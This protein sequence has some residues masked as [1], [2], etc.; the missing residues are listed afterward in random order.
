MLRALAAAIVGL[1][2]LPPAATAQG[3][4]P[5]APPVQTTS[6]FAADTDS[7]RPAVAYSPRRDVFVLAREI[8]VGLDRT[9]FTTAVDRAGHALR[10]GES[11]VGKAP[12]D[13]SDFSRTPR[14]AYNS[15]ADE[16]LVTWIGYSAAAGVREDDLEVLARRLDGLGR[17]VGAV[18]RVSQMGSE[19]DP[20]SWFPVDAVDVTYH[21]SRDEYLVVWDGS[22][23]RQTRFDCEV[24][25]QRLDAAG[26]PIGADDFQISSM[27]PSE[28]GSGC[29]PIDP[30]VVHQP[31]ND[32][33]LVVWWG[34]VEEP[35]LIDG[36]WAQRVGASG[37]L[38]G[39]PVLI[40]D[41]AQ[42]VGFT[43]DVVANGL[44]GEYLVAWNQDYPTDA[45]RGRRLDAA[46]GRLGGELAIYPSPTY[47]MS[48]PVLSFDPW[49]RHYVAVVVIGNPH[50]TA[51]RT[52]FA[53]PLDVTGAP[54]APATPVSES[55]DPV[56]EDPRYT[57]PW[58]LG[59]AIA[60]VPEDGEHM[61]VW[62]GADP[63]PPLAQMRE[64]AARRLRDPAAGTPPAAPRTVADTSP[65]RLAQQRIGRAVRRSRLSPGGGVIVYEPARRRTLRPL[66]RRE[67]IGVAVCTRRRA[68]R[69]RLVTAIRARR[70]ARRMTI[71]AGTGRT[72][73]LRLSPP[74]RAVLRRTGR[75]RV[76][77]A[78]HA[79][80]RTGTTTLQVRR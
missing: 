15:A 4:T 27:W 69:V 25:G 50:D 71:P 13:A 23:E 26:G 58:P 38:T 41:P 73:R 75:A 11:V 32:E 76:K 6:P 2:F 42:R 78:L 45:I 18:I 24:Y 61:V 37:G 59:P 35:Q 54:I 8:T 51:D 36:V 20:P 22:D 10:Q 40:S 34:R 9:V 65:R 49:R 14:L 3:L 79:G 80:L 21:A 67:L 74:Q 7:E 57:A 33:Y 5:L 39:G 12:G 77:L 44:D 46:L 31:A 60:S 55:P 16:F 28:G 62:S 68:C 64:I 43:G 66:R 1:A 29:G 70:A 19:T 47:P 63:E 30:R 72:L 17:P 48:R 53:V 52:V 56:P